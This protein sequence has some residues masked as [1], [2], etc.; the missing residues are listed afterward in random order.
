MDVLH[1]DLDKEVYMKLPLGFHTSNSATMCGLQNIL[2]GLRQTPRCW[3]AKL[4][5]TLTEY[6]FKQ[7]YFIQTQYRHTSELLHW[8]VV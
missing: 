5:T 1:S 7:S 2:Y 8:E 3:F 6:G 4:S